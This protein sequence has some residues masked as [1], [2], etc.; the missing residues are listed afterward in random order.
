[1]AALEFRPGWQRLRGL[2]VRV[3]TAVLSAAFHGLP[4]P[5]T[6]LFTVFPLPFAEL[7]TAFPLPFTAFPLPSTVFPFSTDHDRSNWSQKRAPS[8]VLPSMV[9]EYPL[10]VGRCRR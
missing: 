10:A 7:S 5:S 1:M 6:A 2:E 3:F 4:L 8:E 9:R